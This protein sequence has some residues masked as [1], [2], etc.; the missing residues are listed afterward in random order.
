MKVCLSCGQRFSAQDW[1]CP[2]CNKYPETVDD[3]LSFA[4]DLVSENDGFEAKSF[5]MLFKVEAANFWFRSR[6]RLL[7]WTLRKYFPNAKSL[8]EIGCGTGYVLSGIQSELPGLHLYGSDIFSNGLSFAD[9][10][11]FDVSLFQM[12]ARLIPFEEEFDVIGAFDVLEHIAED[13]VVLQQM[14]QAVKPGGGLILTVPQHRFL[15]S[16]VDEYS[17]HKRRYGKTEL[18]NK[19]EYAGFQVMYSTSFVSFLLPLMLLS[20]MKRHVSTEKFDPLAELRIGRAANRVLE[21]ILAVERR[22]IK[23]G[24]SLPAGGSLL[25]IAKRSRR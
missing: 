25:V 14:F 24:V 17:F 2:S 1:R 23:L 22:C 12:D 6:N 3:F 13:D 11:L 15:W 16:I 9:K 4:P 19:V 8:F 20:R 18:I 5:E 21:K 7:I 10:R